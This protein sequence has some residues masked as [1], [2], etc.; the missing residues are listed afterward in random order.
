MFCWIWSPSHVAVSTPTDR[1]C[2]SASDNVLVKCGAIVKLTRKH[3]NRTL[4]FSNNFLLPKLVDRNSEQVSI[5]T[6][7]TGRS[8]APDVMRLTC[9]WSVFML[10]SIELCYR[11]LVTG[12][13]FF[14]RNILVVPPPSRQTWVVWGFKIERMHRAGGSMTTRCAEA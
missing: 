12:K 9:C 11:A 4:F 8:I 1:R 14:R 5:C 3:V 13:P 7:M 2:W 6:Y 10:R